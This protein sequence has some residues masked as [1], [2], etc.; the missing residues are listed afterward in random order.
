MLA[1]V[2]ELVPEGFGTVITASGAAVSMTTWTEETPTANA[3]WLS[4][5]GA[6]ALATIRYFWFPV[7]LVA[8]PA[9]AKAQTDVLLDVAAIKFGAACG[10]TVKL[11]ELSIQMP[12]TRFWMAT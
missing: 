11:Y 2:Y 4:P 9:G 7:N 5:D 8:S 1:R 6:E 3:L 12:L 10:P